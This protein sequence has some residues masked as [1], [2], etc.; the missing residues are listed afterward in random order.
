MTTSTTTHQGT[1][2]QPEPEMWCVVL[3]R[4]ACSY[5]LGGVSLRDG[6]RSRELPWRSH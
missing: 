6:L 2:R 5:M 3:A 1:L 4:I